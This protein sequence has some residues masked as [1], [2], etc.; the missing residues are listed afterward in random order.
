MA[1]QSIESSI[2]RFGEVLVIAQCGWV[3]A[4]LDPLH[5]VEHRRDNGLRQLW[6][7]MYRV[8]IALIELK[9]TLTAYVRN[10]WNK[11]SS[12]LCTSSSFFF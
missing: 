12:F 9:V 10:F 4:G 8:V 1:N 11:I 3:V 7:T 2:R 5:D 6:E